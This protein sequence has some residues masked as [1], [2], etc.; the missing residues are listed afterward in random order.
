MIYKALFASFCLQSEKNAL[1][2]LYNKWSAG[3][4]QLV[5]Q[6]ICNHQVAGSSPAAG[7][8]FFSEDFR[9]KQT[10][11]PGFFYIG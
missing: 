8:I 4:A 6:L 7:S 1:Y 5:A 3:L 2:C 9:E 11:L 10:F